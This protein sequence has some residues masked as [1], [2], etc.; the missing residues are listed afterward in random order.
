MM[1]INIKLE[2]AVK[3][4]EDLKSLITDLNSIKKDNPYIS[5]NVEIESISWL[6]SDAEYNKGGS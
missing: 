4:T 6:S 5:F 3:S 2:Q 1:H